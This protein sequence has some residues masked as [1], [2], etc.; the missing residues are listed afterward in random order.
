MQ[1]K[2]TKDKIYRCQSPLPFDAV[3]AI[4]VDTLSTFSADLIRKGTV[5]VET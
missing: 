4:D 1:Q 5:Y 2:Q 3:S